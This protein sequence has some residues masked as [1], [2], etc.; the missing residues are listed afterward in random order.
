M[1]KKILIG[2]VVFI[3]AIVLLANF[4]TQG[5]A[6][7]AQ[8]QLSALRSGDSAK[9]YSYTSKD[10]QKATS[11]EEF[12]VFV[13]S[14]PSLSQNESVSFTTKAI[15]NNLGTLKGSLKAKDGSVT[16]VEYQLVK[17]GSDWKILNLRLNPTGAGTTSE[18]PTP[19]TEESSEATIEKVLINDEKSSE[20]VVDTNKNNFS[21]DTPEIF[22]ASYING[23]EVGSKVS[24]E[25]IYLDTGDKVGPA[26]NDIEEGGDIISSF[27]F[28]KP[29]KGWPEGD[30]TIRVYLSTGESK[31]VN[32]S[33][34]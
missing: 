9:A 26:T 30:Y 22:V 21:S 17:E 20:G 28:T 5:I 8:N 23:V 24:A 31:T 13:K 1:I 16:P 25:L 33:V 34:K 7:V 14:Y 11:L 6:D 10:F 4:A 15:E 27:S 19:T 2:L 29:T 18:A 3:I 12:K 32:F